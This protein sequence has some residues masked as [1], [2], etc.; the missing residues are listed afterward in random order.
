MNIPQWVQPACY[1]AAVGA[2]ALAFV[3]F[4]YGGWVTNSGKEKYSVSQTAEGVALA[5]TPYCIARSKDDPAAVTVLA[6]LKA[7]TGYNRR[8]VVE[9]AGWATPM[10]ADKPNT[11]LA[12]ACEVQL[13]KAV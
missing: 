3:G 7:A 13:G 11:Q 12:A 2:A 8:G 1:G 9:K 6:E 10:G 5:L 4:S